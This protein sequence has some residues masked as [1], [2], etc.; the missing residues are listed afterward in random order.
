M[1][2]WTT[3]IEE[4]E[5]ASLLLP[6][7]WWPL[8]G[9]DSKSSVISPDERTRAMRI[10]S[11]ECKYHNVINN[12][13]NCRDAVMKAVINIS[14]IVTVNSKLSESQMEMSSEDVRT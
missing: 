4:T 10:M 6:M 7:D 14:V 2:H 5:A 9:F 1:Q 13:S 3:I 11:D 12:S 8:T